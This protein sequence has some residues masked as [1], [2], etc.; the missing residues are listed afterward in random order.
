MGSTYAQA[1]NQ[2]CSHVNE[3]EIPK[4]VLV[5]VLFKSGI[6]SSEVPKQVFFDMSH[7]RHLSINL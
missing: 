3:T 7:T 4:A 2:E 5:K 1:F 6:R